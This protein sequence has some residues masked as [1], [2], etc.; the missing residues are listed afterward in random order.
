VSR[1]TDCL[2]TGASP[3]GTKTEN[4]RKYGTKLLNEA[5]FLRL[6]KSL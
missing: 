3:G 6:I 4:A 1:H 2:V 5:D